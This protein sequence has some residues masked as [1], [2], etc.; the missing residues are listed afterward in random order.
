MAAYQSALSDLGWTA[1]SSSGATTSSGQS[2]S[3]KPSTAT[4]TT[5]E[6][7]YDFMDQDPSD[8]ANTVTSLIDSYLGKHDKKLKCG[9]KRGDPDHIEAA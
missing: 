3:W 2:A 8:P 1:P 4:T 6:S 7:D 9:H 5:V